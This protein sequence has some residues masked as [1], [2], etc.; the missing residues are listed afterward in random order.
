MKL[1]YSNVKIESGISIPSLRHKKVRRYKINP[2]S[3]VGLLM[4]LEVGQSFVLPIERSKIASL[5]VCV[6]MAKKRIG[7]G[8]AFTVRNYFTVKDVYRG[9]RVWRIA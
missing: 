7:Q 8:Y 4:S 1:N 5:G 3:L 2:N 9:A 6:S